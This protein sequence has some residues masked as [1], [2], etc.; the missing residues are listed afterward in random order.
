MP[1]TVT[2]KLFKKE[3]R[4]EAVK[5]MKEQGSVDFESDIQ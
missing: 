1:L 3:L 5:K 4:D 2:E